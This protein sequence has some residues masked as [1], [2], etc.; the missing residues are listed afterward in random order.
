MTGQEC[1]SARWSNK[2]EIKLLT[3]ISVLRRATFSETPRTMSRPLVLALHWI[4]VTVVGHHSNLII[5]CRF[6]SL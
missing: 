6:P 3:I 1:Y 2:A 4:P 5:L